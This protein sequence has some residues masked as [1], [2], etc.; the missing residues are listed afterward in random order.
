MRPALSRYAAIGL[1]LPRTSA[2][3]DPDDHQRQ[4]LS[5]IHLWLPRQ[6]IVPDHWAEAR[7]QVRAAARQITVRRFGW[8]SV[9]ADDAL[10]MAERRAQEALARIVAGET[11]LRRE[12]KVPYNGADGIPIREEILARHGDEVITRNA[13]GARC[14]N[15]PAA[16]FADVDFENP[17]AHKL[18]LG[19]LA[20]LMVASVSTGIYL[21][22][23][24]VG[25][26]LLVASLLLCAP[27]A[28]ALRRLGVAAQ[29]G[30]EALARRRLATF[31]AAHANWNVRVYRTPG[32]LRLL[33]THR[34][35][36]PGEPEVDEFFR[37]VAVDPIYAR[38]C[39][40][41]QCFRA[42][43]TAKPWRIGVA[44]HMR[45]RPGVWP[46]DP[47]RLA[48]RNSWILDYESRASQFASCRF[49]ESLG[50]GAIHPRI[51]PVIDLHDRESRCNDAAA[52]IA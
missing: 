13:Y 38:M 40:H 30:A 32:G 46:V 10:A 33:A 1:W 12:P 51:Q 41:Q 35:Y 39:L 20:I 3:A 23:G 9:S 25:L 16:L 18:I 44:S 31:M 11:L 28:L 37:C 6:M 45:P 34:P 8:S 43:L 21:G 5:P 22:N 42:R 14:L 50:S 36:D 48:S 17:S 24:R 47:E 27:I 19:T 2:I 4:A 15:S 49:V 29:S 52:S 26:G 7:K